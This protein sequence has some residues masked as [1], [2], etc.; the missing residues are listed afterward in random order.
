VQRGEL[1]IA[2]SIG[3]TGLHRHYSQF[4]YPC[5][6]LLS[7]DRNFWQ[8]SLN[9]AS[10]GIA[11]PDP[12]IGQKHIILTQVPNTYLENASTIVQRM[13]PTETIMCNI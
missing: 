8:L 7:E 5:G 1:Q 6:G 10:C 12:S 4:T 13:I 3:G 9:L 11:P 2:I